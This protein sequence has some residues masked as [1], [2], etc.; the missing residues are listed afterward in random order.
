VTNAGGYLSLGD[1]NIGTM[2]YDVH[3]YSTFKGSA[4]ITQ[5]INRNAVSGGTVDTTSG[6]FWLDT[7]RFYES[8]TSNPNTVLPAPANLDFPIAFSDGPEIQ[9]SYSRP[10]YYTTSTSDQFIDYV[11][12][13]PGGLSAVT[14]IYITLGK[15]T[16][17][18]SGSSTYSNG[19][20]TLPSGS[21]T[22][23]STFDSSGDFP[24]WPKIHNNN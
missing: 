20:W 6:Q 12:F 15:T 17:S 14:N 9:L 22:T 18:W 21:A 3:L 13:R 7:V 8:Q 24:Q 4:D 11:V 2:S 23:P 19:D 10:L 1:G 16:W 5:L